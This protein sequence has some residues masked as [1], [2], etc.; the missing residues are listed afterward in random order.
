MSGIHEHSPNSRVHIEVLHFIR[1]FSIVSLSHN[2]IGFVHARHDFRGYV[3]IMWPFP[4]FSFRTPWIFWNTGSCRFLRAVFVCNRLTWYF[5]FVNRPGIRFREFP[6][7]LIFLC[8]DRFPRAVIHQPAKVYIFQLH[9][10]TR[11]F[12][13]LRSSSRFACRFP[14]RYEF[15]G[16]EDVIRFFA[17]EE[18]AG[19]VE[20]KFIAVGLDFATI[21]SSSFSS[22]I[23]FAIFWEQ[24]I[25]LEF[26]AQQVDLKWLMLNRWRR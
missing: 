22:Y 15:T 1:G 11:C 2:R 16:S 12:V 19:T 13:R 9:L 5:I 7:Y 25:K 4:T 23:L 20:D 10:R 6:Y 18:L 17:D 3:E 21:F 24:L 8:C 26:L 14:C